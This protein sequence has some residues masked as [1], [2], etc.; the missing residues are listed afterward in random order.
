M[1]TTKKVL[2]TVLAGAT[3][4]L[5]SPVFA[6]SYYH[7]RDYRHYEHARDFD[8]YH[9]EYRHYAPRAVI[10][11]RPYYVQRPVIVQQPVYYNSQPAPAMG[12]G[13]VIGSALGTIY[14]YTR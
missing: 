3:L 12:T 7:D 11:E 14:D 13:A 9:H 1:K 4:G 8:R 10:I 6:D 5:A 2:Y